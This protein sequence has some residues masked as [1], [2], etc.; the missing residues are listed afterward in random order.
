M[1]GLYT[2]GI[3]I[4]RRSPPFNEV[5]YGRHPSIKPNNHCRPGS[6][7]HRP[8]CI[9]SPHIASRFPFCL[10]LCSFRFCDSAA[11]LLVCCAP[12][13]RLLC[14][15]ALATECSSRAPSEITLYSPDF[16]VGWAYYLRTYGRL[17]P[18]GFGLYSRLISLAVTQCLLGPLWA[19]VLWASL[20][21]ERKKRERIVQKTSP[22]PIPL[23]YPWLHLPLIPLLALRRPVVTIPKFLR[24]TLGPWIQ[25]S[26]GDESVDGS[27]FSPVPEDD[28]DDFAFPL[29]DPWYD[30]GG[31]FPNIPGKVSLP[32]SNWEWM[33]RGQEAT[34]DRVWTPPLSS[35]SDL[36]I[37]RGDM[38][39]VPIDFEFPC[40]AA[41][42]WFHWVADE[43]MDAEFCALLE[44]AGVAEAIL[45][46]RSCNMYRNTEALRQI[47][48]RWCASTHTFFFSWGELTIT[49]ED[50]E[51]HWLLPVLGDMDPFAVEMSEEETV[52]EQALMARAST[53]INAWSVYFAKATEPTIRRA[54]FVAYWL[55]KCLFGDAPYYSMKPLYFRLAVKIS[56]G[57]RF[58]L[59]AMFLGYLYLQLDS[60]CLDEIRGGSCHFI[61]TCFNT[62][63]LQTFLWERSL[64][65]QEVGN[66]NSQIRAKFKNMS[67]QILR[68]YP[69][70]RTNLPLVYRWVSLRGR[71]PDLVPSMDFEEC[72]LWRP[73]SYRY[74]DFSCH[75]VM[76]WFSDIASQS[77]ELSPDDTRSLNLFV[78]GESGVRR[79]FG[80]DQ[81]VPGSPSETLPRT[82]NMAPFLNDH[83]FDYWSA[84]VSRMTMS[85]KAE[86]PRVPL[87]N[88]HAH[89]METTTLSPPTQTA[90][91]YAERQGLGFAE[92][93]G[94]R[95]GWILYST[96]IPSSWKESV[97]VVEERLR[98]DSKRG[99]GSKK[100]DSGKGASSPAASKQKPKSAAKASSKRPKVA[101]DMSMIPPSE[102]GD[103]ALMAPGTSKK[104]QRNLPLPPTKAKSQPRSKSVAVKKAKSKPTRKSAV[105]PPSSSE[106]PA[107]ESATP[108][109]KES[110][111]PTPLV[112]PYMTVQGV[113]GKLLQEQVRS[114]AKRKVGDK[115]EGSDR[116]PIVI[117]EV[118]GGDDVVD[119]GAGTTEVNESI[120][121]R[122][123][124]ALEP[125]DGVAAKDS[126]IDWTD[127]DDA[128]ADEAL[129]VTVSDE[130]VLVMAD[131][132]VQSTTSIMA[133]EAPGETPVSMAD[134]V[135]EAREV[136]PVMA[137]VT[138]VSMADETLVDVAHETAPVTV[139]ETLAGMA[140][141]TPVSIAYGIIPVVANFNTGIIVGSA[142]EED[143]DPG[144]DSVDSEEAIADEPQPLQIIPFADQPDEPRAND[145]IE[146]HL[147]PPFARM[148]SVV[149][150]VSLFGVAPHFGRILREEGSPMVVIDH[151]S[152]GAFTGGQVP[153]LEGIPIQG[154]DGGG[155]ADTEV[156]GV[157]V[158]P[159]DVEAPVLVE[160]ESVAHVVSAA[161]SS[162]QTRSAVEVIIPGRVAA[163]FASFEE[164]APNPYPDWHFWRFEGP[165]VAYGNFWVYQDAVPLLQGLSAKFGDFTT[166]FKFGAGFGGPMISLLGSVLADM[167]RTSFKTL[168]ESKI[169]SW[170]SVVQDLIAV[171]FDLDFLLEHL[172]K[173]AR[174]FFGEAIA[175]EMK[176]VQEQISSLQSTLAV[177]V[178]YQGELMSAAA[179]S[180]TTVEVASPI[181]GLFD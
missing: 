13:P 86:G 109:E 160:K 25:G 67:R 10:W 49:L 127:S 46:S 98:L 55:C 65:Y 100:T 64:N 7:D 28:R 76:Y 148:T 101:M 80:L 11:H 102:L 145:P 69:D 167:R 52:V 173:V 155:T 57:H 144:T 118:S 116:V 139:D 40:S 97:K 9:Y 143:Y 181:D 146:F 81:S 15:K 70:L 31:N 156:R 94:P 179:A 82:P 130:A 152:S 178:S 75:S 59:A 83:A 168:S 61:T 50:V 175:S 119:A 149:E 108:V 120:T 89:P 22:P 117:E 138:L 42:D 37:Q 125:T 88:H 111:I 2:V 170:R 92:W 114:Q 78:C 134:V 23:F 39:P 12:F 14:R 90:I 137:D 84:S 171:G 62:S 54:A 121:E 68:R 16:P 87:P 115:G 60:V 126:P 176:V 71:D 51:N 128:M 5:N 72:V 103:R 165:L 105:A 4:C 153:A 136:T 34:A 99:K 20:D 159:E 26:V 162:S 41:A 151:P 85:D 104:K 35:I 147:N 47:L 63:A 48:R 27:R 133:E 30:N 77:F 6:R 24:Q 21:H 122:Q 79:Q 91:S 1:L 166:H 3:R 43:F 93:D 140:D 163:F 58:P 36:R 56:F 96:A 172:R 32:P 131:E 18:I 17:L 150:G 106:E 132:A 174:K 113:K 161:P 142:A 112:A 157:G 107:A 177:L 29:L 38:Q 141:R 158:V 95:D 33:L 44:R 123:E 154:A 135:P 53:R 180:P 164:R 129:G 66:D 19:V 74:A 73:Y 45:L 8:V 124:V 110:A 169:L